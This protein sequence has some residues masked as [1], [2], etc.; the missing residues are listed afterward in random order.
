MIINSGAKVIAEGVT[1][2]A[3]SGADRFPPGG[4]WE[5]L[6]TGEPRYATVMIGEKAA[7]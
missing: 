4:A 2:C 7:R 1:L 5:R 3:S 6:P